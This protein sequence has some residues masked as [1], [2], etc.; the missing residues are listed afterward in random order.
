MIE[1]ELLQYGYLFVFLGSIA[2]G[3]ATLLAAAF[4]AHRGYMQFAWVLILA[5]LGTVIASQVSFEFGRRKGRAKLAAYSTAA[6]RIERISQ[7]TSRFG[8]AFVLASRFLFGFRT[9]APVV[10]GA[11][12]MNPLR[13]TIWNLAGAAI[14]TLAFGIAGY[15]GAQL[16]TLFMTDIRRHEKA[17]AIGIA[18]SA[19]LMI[20]R[21][22]RGNDWLDFLRLRK[23]R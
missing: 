21:A 18:I 7:W 14:W 20:G 9:L 16:L 2:E 8:G 6:S 12:G 4:L 13:F 1:L 10:C 3:D 23:P 11:T 5:F 15:S 17:I 22:T 19:L